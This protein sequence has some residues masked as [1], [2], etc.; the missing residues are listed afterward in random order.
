MREAS[1][2]VNIHDIRLDGGKRS[3]H[4]IGGR[5]VWNIT[6][7]IEPGR[8]DFRL[9]ASAHIPRKPRR[10]IRIEQDVLFS[11]HRLLE[12]ILHVSNIISPRFTLRYCRADYA[13][14]SRLPSTRWMSE[15]KLSSPDLHSPSQ[16]RPWFCRSEF[17]GVRIDQFRAIHAVCPSLVHGPR[18]LGDAQRTRTD[19]RRIR[20]ALNAPLDQSRKAMVE[21]AGLCLQVAMNESADRE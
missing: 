20:N 13:H 14:L 11:R 4:W 10:P 18:W 8:Y 17:S 19:L 9:C 7:T 16:P 15:R 5:F 3:N 12:R 2:N 1:D 21:F 6:E